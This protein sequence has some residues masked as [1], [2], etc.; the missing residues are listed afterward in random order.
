MSK[1]SLILILLILTS[2]TDKS[3]KE[4]QIEPSIIDSTKQV[5]LDINKL[6][7]NEF[8][9]DIK[10]DKE[11]DNWLKYNELRVKIKEFKQGDLSHFSSD[12]KTIETFMKEFTNTVPLN[13]NNESI[14]ARILVV[15]TMYFRLNDI[16][17]MKNSSDEQIQNALENLLE[18]FSNLNYQINKKFERD[19]QRVSRPE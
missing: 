17:N 2:C 1:V 4:D 11:I 16:A 9:L 8:V 15:E 13:I 5:E 18:G 12:F 6:N 14:Q 10:A 7:F 3:Q 19:F